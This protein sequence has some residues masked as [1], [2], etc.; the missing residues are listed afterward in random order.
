MNHKIS[1]LAALDEQPENVGNLLVIF[2]Y[3]LNIFILMN[4]INR[5]NA[6]VKLHSLIEAS[7]P[8]ALIESSGSQNLY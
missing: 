6:N 4:K 5:V 2:K 8:K 1:K 7:K 3:Y